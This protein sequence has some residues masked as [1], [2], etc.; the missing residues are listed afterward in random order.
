H[1]TAQADH[2]AWTSAHAEHA[3]A[4]GRACR[5][6]PLDHGARHERHDDALQRGDPRL[7]A[8]CS[9]ACDR[10]DRD[11][12]SHGA[13]GQDGL[14]V[15]AQT[16]T[17]RREELYSAVWR[18]PATEVAKRY[19]MSS[20]AL[21]KICDRLQVPTPTRGYWARR[22]VGIVD[23]TPPLPALSRTAESE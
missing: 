1:R 15:R 20:N 23:P 5:D 8:G 4:R 19:G 10:E 11:P 6:D 2:T 16:V 21:A 12:G 22:A 7:A 17:Y 18:E 14:I 13:T 3:R 9:C